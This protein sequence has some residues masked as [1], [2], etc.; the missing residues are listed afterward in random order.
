M[1]LYNVAIILYTLYV[2]SAAAV[3]VSM[4]SNV[5]PTVTLNLVNVVSAIGLDFP[6]WYHLGLYL[7]ISDNELDTI[8]A[9]VSDVQMRFTKMVQKWLKS[10]DGATWEDLREALQKL[11]Q[12][13]LAA[14]ISTKYC[15]EGWNPP[16]QHISSTENQPL[17]ARLPLCARNLEQPEGDKRGDYC[18]WIHKS[19]MY[20]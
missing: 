19:A 17:R 1:P 3:T 18:K 14:E 16:S 8:S 15:S 2:E 7:N 11:G 13:K 12:R 9:N 6:Q 5:N 4:A 10:K 20:A